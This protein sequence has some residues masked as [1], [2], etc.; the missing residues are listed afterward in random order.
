MFLVPAFE[1]YKRKL[2]DPKNV[3]FSKS[4]AVSNKIDLGTAI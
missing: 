4:N 3:K 1:K 2:S